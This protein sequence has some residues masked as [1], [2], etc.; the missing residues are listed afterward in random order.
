MGFAPVGREPGLER[1]EDLFGA[2]EGL[3]GSWTG[4]TGRDWVGEMTDLDEAG[5]DSATGAGRI[6]RAG[7]PGRASGL[8]A[9]IGL[10][11]ASVWGERK[12]A[13]LPR[14]AG[15]DGAG[16]GAEERA[17]S[18]MVR[19]GSLAAWAGLSKTRMG[20]PM[21][22]DSEAASIW[23]VRERV[24]PRSALDWLAWGSGSRWEGASG[25]TSSG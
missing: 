9:M 20:F 6:K 22:T 14:T 7:L 12:R 4:E 1:T 19:V 5:A 3:D 8:P 2:R 11:A 23:G 13:G 21:T 10:Q 15:A 18:E 25:L 24:G 17:E 16:V